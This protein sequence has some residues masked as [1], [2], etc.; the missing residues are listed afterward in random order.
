MSIAV[1][2]PPITTTRRPISRLP[3]SLPGAGARYRRRRPYA[4]HVLAFEGQR[5]DAGQS[6][7]EEHRVE[8]LPQ[9]RQRDV[10]AERLAVLDADTADT[11]DER[12]LGLREVVRHLVGGDAVFVQAARLGPGFEDGDV[13]AAQRQAMGAG[14]TSGAG[15]DH[16]D[17]LAR[18]WARAKGCSFRSNSQSVA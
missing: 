6:H 12:H 5:V 1:L 14:E 16:G 8:I 2:P 11:H 10:A 9:L 17:A 15:A 4:G 18:R 3:L 13:M 7:A